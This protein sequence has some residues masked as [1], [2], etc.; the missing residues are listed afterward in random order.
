MLII[1]VEA[2]PCLDR[3]SSQAVE[4]VDGDV[5]LHVGKLWWR[6]HLEQFAMSLR[7]SHRQNVHVLRQTKIGHKLL[8][9]SS[10][11]ASLYAWQ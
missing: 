5:G 4:L 9:V 6:D 11:C 8:C 2:V 10:V 7:W 3:V 1:S